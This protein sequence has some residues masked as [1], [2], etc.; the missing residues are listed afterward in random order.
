MNADVFKLLRDV[1]TWSSKSEGTILETLGSTA[2][3]G[4]T[5]D[6]QGCGNRHP[7]LN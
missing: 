6:E 3:A 7:Q 2:D 4:T 1:G 5:V